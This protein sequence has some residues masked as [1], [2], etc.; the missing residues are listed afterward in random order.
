MD[1]WIPFDPVTLV[2]G[3]HLLVDVSLLCIY[4]CA[5]IL[6]SFKYAVIDIHFSY[7]G[8]LSWIVSSPV[9]LVFVIIPC[10]SYI[11]NSNVWVALNQLTSS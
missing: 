4:L 3:I 6:L 2:Q 8:Y 9:L 11:G 7:L 10:N 5:Y 1:P